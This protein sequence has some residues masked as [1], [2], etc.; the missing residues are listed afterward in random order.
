MKDIILGFGVYF[1][2]VNSLLNKNRAVHRGT[3]KPR[4]LKVGRYVDCLIDINEYLA[5]FLGEIITDK[6][7]ITDLN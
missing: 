4:G 6:I 5:L 7:G 2:P 1:L 3:R